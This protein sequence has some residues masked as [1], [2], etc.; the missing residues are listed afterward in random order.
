MTRPPHVFIAG[1]DTDYNRG[2]KAILMGMVQALKAAIPDIVITIP[3]INPKNFA[4]EFQVRTVPRHHFFKVMSAIHAADLVLWGGGVA[5]Q[6]DT[7]SVKVPFWLARQLLTTK[8]VRTPVMGIAGGIGPLNTRM[9]RYLAGEAANLS[10]LMVTRDQGAADLLIDI[11]VP[12]AKVRAAACT[13]M[14]LQGQTAELGAEL[15]QKEGIPV[16]K[17]PL[18]GLATRLWFH[19]SGG[20][21]PH[22]WMVKLGISSLDRTPPRFQD[23]THNLGR[24]AD[25][26]IEQYD[27]HVVFFPMYTVSHESDQK[28]CE[29][30]R[31]TMQH[32]DQA[33]VIHGDYPIIQFASAFL[34]LS[35][36][37]GVRMHSTILS[38]IANVP[39]LTLYY[40]PKGLKYFRMIGQEQNAFPIEAIADGNLEPLQEKINMLFANS[41]QIKTELKQGVQEVQQLAQ[42][43][44][45][46]VIEQLKDL[47]FMKD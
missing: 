36:F 4:E 3:A 15:L 7:S 9:G 44:M 22:E 21:L 39:T 25:W 33:T 24:L 41:E 34:H 37:V 1:G 26:L 31:A 23:F 30:T 8:V 14:L 42:Q 20:W 11:G 27:V 13:A 28:F 32:P 40:V 47:G 16:G 35:A 45:T 29:E 10:R 5:L 6:D 43:N 38:T 19:H 17:K 12:S 46:Y 2:D 18:V